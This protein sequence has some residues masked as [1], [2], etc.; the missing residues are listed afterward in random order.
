MIAKFDLTRRELKTNITDDNKVW[1]VSPQD[2]NPQFGELDDN[3]SKR[4]KRSAIWNT[5]GNASGNN[6]KWN[7]LLNN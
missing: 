4:E 3:Q 7:E 6:A 1:T 2:L 5:V